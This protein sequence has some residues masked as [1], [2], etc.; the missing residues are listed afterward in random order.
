MDLVPEFGSALVA[1]VPELAELEL[2]DS[3]SR[4][5]SILRFPLPPV[6]VVANDD[7]AQRC[8]RASA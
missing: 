3:A 1:A 2:S 5:D 8:R 6:C 4:P 7:R